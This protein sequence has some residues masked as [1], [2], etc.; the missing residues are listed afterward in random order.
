MSLASIWREYGHSGSYRSAAICVWI[1]DLQKFKGVY[2]PNPRCDIAVTLTW[3]WL[4][5]GLNLTWVRSLRFLQIG[6]YM[7]LNIWP[8][9]IQRI[10]F[11]KS[12]VWYCR[13]FHM[14]IT[15]PW[16]QSDLS[17]VTHI[18][19]DRQLY[20]FENMTLKNSKAFICQTINVILS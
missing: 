19:K 15:Y 7:C 3:R 8:W 5:L 18:L 9:K 6:S 16:S 14:T 17:M 4:V 10:S 12:S 2:F 20:E 11:A 1:Y 13:N